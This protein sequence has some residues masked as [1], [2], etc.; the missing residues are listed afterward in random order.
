MWRL[1]WFNVTTHPGT[2]D[3]YSGLVVA[4]TLLSL[5]N[6]TWHGR[7]VVLNHCYKVVV[8]LLGLAICKLLQVQQKY[9]VLPAG[10]K[11]S[12]HCP[13]TTATH[14]FSQLAQTFHI[15]ARAG[16]TRR[17]ST[18]AKSSR[19]KW[20]GIFTHVQKL[21]ILQILWHARSCHR[22]HTHL[23]GQLEQ[24]CCL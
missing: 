16:Y 20:M 7:L 21:K 9:R 17:Y 23:S 2:C 15:S 5:Q 13:S 19:S 14:R 11:I 24:V 18:L 22:C 3:H 6:S 12:S 8:F 4:T 10:S 1:Q